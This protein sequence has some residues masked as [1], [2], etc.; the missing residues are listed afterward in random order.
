MLF[1]VLY[2]QTKFVVDN[3]LPGISSIKTAFEQ[4]KFR[5]MKLQCERYG[6]RAQTV[7]F[8]TI[9]CW[10]MVLADVIGCSA[11]V[12]K[13]VGCTPDI[14]ER[15]SLSNKWSMSSKDLISSLYA[16]KS[17]HSNSNLVRQNSDAKA[18][19]GW[20]DVLNKNVSADVPID[21]ANEVSRFD[22]EEEV[23]GEQEVEAREFSTGNTQ[24]SVP[25]MV[26]AK[27]VGKAVPLV[28]AAPVHLS[29]E[30][31]EILG[32]MMISLEVI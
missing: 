9:G 14:A 8:Y 30:I 2:R 1:S 31:L 24:A 27:F 10:F 18:T 20:I 25:N 17:S 6:L 11:K 32:D 13:E 7:G 12:G 19:T 3:F 23:S 4:K 28:A 16:A 5:V 22:D 15:Q 29:D 21:N 26:R